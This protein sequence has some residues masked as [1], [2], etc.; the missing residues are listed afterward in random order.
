MNDRPR[1][2]VTMLLPAMALVLASPTWAHGGESGDDAGLDACLAGKIE[3]A[4]FSLKAFDETTGRDLRNYPPDRIV[5]YEHMS[6]RMRFDD[7]NEKRFS[8]VETLRCTPIAGP[9]ESVTLDAVGLRIGAVTVAGSPVEHYHDGDRLTLRFDPPLSPA[10]AHELVIEYDCVEPYDGMFFTPASEETPHYTAQVHTQGQTV[11]NRHWFVC[12]DSPNE[13][14]TTELIVD[15]PSGYSVS[16][17]GRLVTTSDDGRRAVWHYLQ[18]KPHVSYLVSLVIGKFDIVE[19]PHDRV[20]M[21]VWA[22]PGLGERVM[23][24]YGRTGEM[25]DLFEKRLGRP[26]PWDRYD[27]LL[28]KNFGSGGMENTS[29]TTMY[30]TAVLDETALLDGDLEGLIA[31]ELCHQWTGDMITCKGWTHIWLNEGWATYGAALWFEHRDGEDGY[32]DS[33]RRSFRRVSSRD[34]TTNELPM[35]S[36]VWERPWETF[37][38]RANPYPKGC[39]ILH[40]LRM[41]LGDEVF[42]EGVHLYMNRHALG[43]VETNDFRYAMEEVS[44]RGLEWFFDQW[45]YRPGVPDLDVEVRYDGAARELLIEVA[46]TQHIDERTPAFRFTLPVYVRTEGGS[47]THE[48]EVTEKTTSFRATLD[49]PPDIVAV[50]PYLAVLKKISVDKPLHLRTTQA[51][52]GPTIAARHAAFSALR[53]HDT[54]GTIQLLS[55]IIEDESVRY[56]LRNAAVDT[57][58]RYGSKQARERLL[59]IATAGVEEARVRATVVGKLQDYDAEEVVELL[60]EVADSDPS[61]ATRVAAIRALAHHEAAEYADLIVELVDFPS[62]H[63]RV[64]RA[65]LSALAE[66]DDPRGLDLGIRYSAYGFV[67]RSRPAAIEAVGKLAHHDTDRAVTHLIALLD[68]PERRAVRAAGA[69]LAEVGDERAVA[70]IEAMSESH[71]SE[72]VRDRAADWLK[73]IKEATKDS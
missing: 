44:G 53:D 23:Q 65:A 46:Q 17:N 7:L 50:D 30:S 16:G 72:R 54:P 63:D 21:Q 57:L 60:A 40:M 5:D 14:M 64:G 3:R 18:D 51:R 15:V 55:E 26:Y 49:G 67:D 19:I 34:K 8:A 11:T 1:P 58:A 73:K 68:D 12:H 71:P 47:R 59:A 56:T 62:Q 41:M 10:A 69:A 35:V 43:T 42:F 31:H 61:Y 48:I 6:L 39:S 24:T 52:L 13:R 28:A 36:P 29:A 66:L 70:P 22:P 45:C 9:V 2:G 38:R 4:S 33:I 27:Q 20:P 37:R 32:L 25:I